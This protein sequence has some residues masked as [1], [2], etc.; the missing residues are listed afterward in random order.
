MILYASPI[1]S[2]LTKQEGNRYGNETSQRRNQSMDSRIPNQE[3]QGR[4]GKV[5][6]STKETTNQKQDG[7]TV[8]KNQSASR[9]TNQTPRKNPWEFFHF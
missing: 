6:H 8:K 9:L 7:C 3:K 1:F 4:Q 5:P 2:L